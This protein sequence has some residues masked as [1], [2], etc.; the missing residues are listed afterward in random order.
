MAEAIS[1]RLDDREVRRNLRKLSRS[2]MPRAMADALNKTSFEILDAEKAH[3]ARVF[4]GPQTERFLAGRGSFRFNKASAGK[5]QTEI[6]PTPGPDGRRLRILEQQR[7][8]GIFTPG[9]EGRFVIEKRI[10]VPVEAKRTRRGRVRKRSKRSFVAGSAVLERVGRGRR[11]RVRVL[12]ALTPQIRIR[13]RFEFMRT[14]RDTAQRV[15]VSKVRRSV[16][17][18]RLGVRR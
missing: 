8:G 7:E 17:K 14:A 16:E 6:F 2:E 11:S 12:F 13:P 1:L 10:A 15:F 5:L 3:A 9:D 4:E 18:I